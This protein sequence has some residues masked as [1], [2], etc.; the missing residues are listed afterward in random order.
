MLYTNTT[1]RPQYESERTRALNH[2][3]RLSA[4]GTA[5]SL[6][7]V[8]IS[9]CT[10]GK[11]SSPP[12]AQVSPQ[13]VASPSPTTGTA[14]GTAFQ[15]W[16]NSQVVDAFK[17]AGL[18][19]DNPRPMSKPQDYGAAPTVDIE[20]TQFNIP[21]LGEGGGGHIYSFAS[22]NDLEKMIKYYADASANNFSWV[23]VRD[24]LLVQI[25]GRLEEEKAKRYE[26]ALGNVK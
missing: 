23:Y 26:A 12:P 3:T 20:A 16:K 13:A 7:L 17:A 19:A 22:E 6:S 2:L 14:A 8:I 1:V 11:Q 25:D 18:E 15:K 9:A 10:S 4:T 24:N 21:S 5:M